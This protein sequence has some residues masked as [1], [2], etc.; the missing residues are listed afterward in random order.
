MRSRLRLSIGRNPGAMSAG[1]LKSH[2]RLAEAGTAVK[3]DSA[4]H[5]RTGQPIASRID[6]DDAASC[7][8]SRELH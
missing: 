1:K 4:D 5:A 7:A 6:R 2:N 8:V 3:F